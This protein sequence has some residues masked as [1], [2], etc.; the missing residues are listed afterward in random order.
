M[1][2]TCYLKT[3]NLPLFDHL[4]SRYIN[5]DLH[6]GIHLNNDVSTF[7]LYNLNG[8]LVGYQNYNW[9]K[10]KEKM[11]DPTNG[12]YY[13]YRKKECWVPW[14]LET[15]Y[16]SDGP[17]FVTEGI[18]D[19]CRL[20]NHGKTAF[21]VMTNNPP[22]DFKNFL[23]FVPRPIVAIL[24]NDPAGKKLAKFGDFVE[25]VPNGDLGDADESYVLYLL[26]KYGTTH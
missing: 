22:G 24:D 3:Q 23:S 20:T 6:T 4:K 2:C 13:T 9:K 17:I 25:T 19:A 1:Y 21:A 8:Q 11:N 14:G 7:Y 5:F 10:S 26:N 15:Y 16:W 12:R 18:F